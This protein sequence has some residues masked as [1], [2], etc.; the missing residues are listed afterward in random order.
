MAHGTIDIEVSQKLLAIAAE[1]EAEA[2]AFD[3]SDQRPDDPTPSPR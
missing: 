1:L 3:E 2:T